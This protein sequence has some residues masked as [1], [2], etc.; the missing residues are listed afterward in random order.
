MSPQKIHELPPSEYIIR[1]YQIIFLKDKSGGEFD[2]NRKF[3]KPLKSLVNGNV[4]FEYDTQLAPLYDPYVA[5][6]VQSQ[7][8]VPQ[9]RIK[10]DVEENPKREVG[11]SKW[12]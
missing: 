1:I 7:Y 5:K 6:N 12:D 9:Q 11:C 8:L 2:N 3:K 4:I 10:Y